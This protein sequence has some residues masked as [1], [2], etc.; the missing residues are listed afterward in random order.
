MID[1]LNE[2][3]QLL[4]KQDETEMIEKSKNQKYNNWEKQFK[5]EK[6]SKP[7]NSKNYVSNV[8]SKTNYMCQ[9]SKGGHSI[10]FCEK[11]KALPVA[12]RIAEIKN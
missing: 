8:A 4:E 11:M 12:S 7:H 3:C 2:W 1:F 6:I 5:Q 10:Y 9:Y